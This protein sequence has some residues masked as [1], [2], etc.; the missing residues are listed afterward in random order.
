MERPVAFFSAGVRLAGDLYLPDGGAERRAGVV[1]CCG[2]T[3]IKDLYLNDMAR[4][5][6]AAGYVGLTFDYR[7]WG[8]SDGEPRLRLSPYGRVEDTQAA[9]TFLAAQPEVD[10]DRLGLY[11]ISYGGST[12]VFTAAIDQRVRAVV[13]VTGVGDGPRWMRGVRTPWDYR[14][15]VGRGM[16]DWERQVQN[17]HSEMADRGE[18]LQHDPL[19]AE[20]AA[21]ARRNLP[22]AAMQVPLEMIHE[23]LHFRP[24]WVVDRIAPRAV[25]FVT[26][27]ADELVLPEESEQMYRRAGE[28]K[29]LVVLSGYGH[30][31]VFVPPAIDQVIEETVA[32]YRRYL[33]P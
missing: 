21:Q 13:S 27:D 31:Q 9:L 30:Y 28:P 25:L 3:G 33:A 5:L 22:G 23:T 24:E 32:W 12:A 2:Y 4:W 11:G 18:V 26:S 20:L 6:S 15:L 10:R 17:G 19:S 8:K 14:T 29:K 16:A 1:L 7:G